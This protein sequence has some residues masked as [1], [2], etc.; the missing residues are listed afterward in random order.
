M[1]VL[2]FKSGHLGSAVRVKKW[3]KGYFILLLQLFVINT[4]DCNIV[5]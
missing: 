4:C 2:A 5:I 1:R 3:S